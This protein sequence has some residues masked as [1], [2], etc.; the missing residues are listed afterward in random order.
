MKITLQGE[1]PSKKNG[2]VMNCKTKRSFPSQRYEKWHNAVVS[3]LHYLLLTKKL[4]SFECM[5][6]K[7]TITFWH[8]DKVRRDSDN[9][10][11]SIL[12]TLVDAKILSDD[13]WK[14]IPEKHIYDKYEKGKARC[15]IEIEPIGEKS[16]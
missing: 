15:E 6:V 14:V 8:G 11:S 12:D 1:T 4:V 13:N 5:A 7:M 16:K 2:R 10:L 3:Q 9:Q